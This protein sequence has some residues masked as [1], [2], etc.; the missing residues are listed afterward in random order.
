MRTTETL[1]GSY[2]SVN[3]GN[4]KVF[5]GKEKSL[6]LNIDHLLNLF[7]GSSDVLKIRC[8]VS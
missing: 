2:G 6:L 7:L 1:Y 4:F 3:Y 5:Q 8:K